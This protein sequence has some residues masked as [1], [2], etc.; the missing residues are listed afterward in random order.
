MGKNLKNYLVKVFS[1][2]LAFILV[3]P[4]ELFAM[5][6]NDTKGSKYTAATSVMGLAENQEGEEV[7]DDTANQGLIKSET[8]TDE[9]EDYII[10]KSANLSKTTG[11]IDYKIVV[12]AKTE[13]TKADQNLLV[14][15]G[16]NKNTDLRELKVEKLTALHT[17]KTESEIKYQAQEP[18][19][20]Y[21]NDAYDTLG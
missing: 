20:L 11:Q 21:T 1:L 13:D 12:K 19:I 2:V 4:T 6:M 18:G 14:T 5:A 7:L 9:T 8:S 16:I 3:F 15:F 10:E 17:D